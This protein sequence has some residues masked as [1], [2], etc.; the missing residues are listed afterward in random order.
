M[1]KVFIAAAKRTAIGSFL[2]TLK[3]MHPSTL[4]AAVVKAILEETNI[5]PDALDEVIVGNIL[6]AGVGQG[7][8]RQVAV[9]GGVSHDVPAYAVNHVCCSGMK[10]VMN[11]A[12]AI[13][14]GQ[15]DLILA[16]G[17]ES[18]SGAPF[19]LPGK[20]RNGNKLGDFTATDHMVYDALTDAFENYHMGIT[21]EN[22]AERYAITREAQDA[23]ALESQRKAIAAVDA[24][25]FVREI[26]PLTVKAGRTEI[27]FDKDEYPNRATNAE[28]MAALR[29]AF[30]KDG[31]VT[32]GN[33]SGINDGAS[34]TLI[35]G[36]D[37]VK[38]YNL[39]PLAEI[40]GYAQAGIDP[41]IMG[42]GPVP[43]VKKALAKTGLTLQ[44]MDLLELNEAFAAQ[45]LGVVHGLSEAHGLSRE[46]ITAKTNVGGGA[47]ALGH[48]IGASGNRI[49]VTLVHG[50]IR[51]GLTYGLAS[52][53]AGGG[54]GTAVV[55]RNVAK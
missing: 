34:M 5:A 21:A 35:A 40:L 24:G 51:T 36:E 37:A 4:G 47:I 23:Y 12:S 8:A 42:L 16:G 25:H 29:P 39:T 49:L 10:A 46:E 14:A 20:V 31:T 30:K 22:V 54:M 52:L 45:A 27:V 7:I 6:S 44:D 1:K 32:A 55:V 18:M 11:A 53:C 33:A 19:I 28:K 38:K 13:Q 48:P 2:G 41:A 50:L 3:D 9:K 15:A 17:V 43:A 26:L